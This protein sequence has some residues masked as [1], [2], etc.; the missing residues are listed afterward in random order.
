MEKQN[1][2][3]IGNRPRSLKNDACLFIIQGDEQV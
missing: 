3:G 2:P 1:G